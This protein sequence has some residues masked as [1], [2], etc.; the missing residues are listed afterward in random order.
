M[1]STIAPSAIEPP[2]LS[3]RTGPLVWLRKN[4]FR[5]L[6][7]TI[8]T[9]IV[10]A[11]LVTLL[12]SFLQWAIGEA[13]WAVI[14]ENFRVLMQ[15]LYP[16]E[17]GWRVA[18]SVVI[19]MVLAGASAAIWGR[20]AVSVAVLLLGAVII[21]VL[22]PLADT[23]SWGDSTLSHYLSGELLPMLKVLQLPVLALV[24]CLV[25]GYGAG[26]WARAANR[27]RASRW[28]L[29]LWLIS[30]PVIFFLVR[31]LG[32]AQTPVLPLV[33][34][35]QW[36]GLLLTFMLA[37]VAIVC[38][39]PL[40]ILLALGRMSGGAM[41]S[42]RRNA[43]NQPLWWLNP[44]HGGVVVADWWRSLGH[45]PIIKLFCILYIELLRGVPLVTVLFTA[46]LIVPIA[47][48]NA[49]IDAVVRAM[50]A[51]TLFEAAYIAEIVR[52]GLQAIPVGQYEAA[53]ALGLNAVQS[54]FF[55][56]LP[57]ALRIVIPALVGQF[58]TMFKDTS[59]VAIVGL[60][61][62]LGIVQGIIAQKEFTGRQRET[63]VFIAI[64]Y[65]VFSYGMSRGA[66][67]L[68]R[69]GSGG[70]AQKK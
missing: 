38:C 58:I 18:L 32:S 3:G 33:P 60:L 21:F 70:L 52:G 24:A 29:A 64:V 48:G 43:K 47:L 51:L 34:T 37:F 36:G 67:Q 8:L 69:S 5:T 14:T 56:T 26:R 62:L 41:P 66:R 12:S 61:D 15:G 23:V 63:F 39:F 53:K 55:I 19:V 25:I 20:D 2:R 57:Q 65:F 35:N 9:I 28:T 40:G 22:L 1:T 50:V 44:R 46:N 59:L 10:A 30:I 6:P 31:G 45:Y 17:Q 13:R 49:E 54:T 68:E 16:V 7:D 42:T 27:Q 4:L 11:V